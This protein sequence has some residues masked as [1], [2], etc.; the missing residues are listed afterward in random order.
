MFVRR[1]ATTVQRLPTVDKDGTWIRAVSRI[2]Q[3]SLN[4]AGVVRGYDAS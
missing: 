2:G 1:K 3:A 4:E